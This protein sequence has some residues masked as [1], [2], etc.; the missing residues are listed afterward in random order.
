M[1]ITRYIQNIDFSITR[2]ED[3]ARESAKLLKYFS[4]LARQRNIFKYKRAIKQK[5][6]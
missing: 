1:H 6:S 3:L 2:K 4:A 5:K